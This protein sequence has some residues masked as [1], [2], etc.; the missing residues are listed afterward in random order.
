[1]LCRGSLLG[2]WNVL[3]TW[4]CDAIDVCKLWRD[5]LRYLSA[6]LDAARMTT[7]E[8]GGFAGSAT[9]I[10]EVSVPSFGATLDERLLEVERIARGLAADGRRLGASLATVSERLEV[11]VGVQLD[12]VARSFSLLRNFFTSNF[13][14]DLEIDF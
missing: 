9:S 1:M 7:R 2:S 10:M 12:P 6:V 11:I 13:V 4:S 3:R 5:R 8:A 14:N